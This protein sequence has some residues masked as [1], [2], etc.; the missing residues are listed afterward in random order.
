MTQECHA[1]A[2]GGQGAGSLARHP[3]LHGDTLQRRDLCLAHD[4]DPVG[5][6]QRLLG[7]R[8]GDLGTHVRTDLGDNVCGHLVDVVCRD[9]AGRAHLHAFA[10]G[11]AQQCGGKLGLAAIGVADEKDMGF[12]VPSI[13]GAGTAVTYVECLPAARC[14]ETA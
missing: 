5:S 4:D 10:R 8:G 14:L 6:A 9:E 13:L 11:L 3:A 1:F 12:L 2:F 7:Q